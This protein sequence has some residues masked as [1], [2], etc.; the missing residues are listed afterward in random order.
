MDVRR[1][2]WILISVLAIPGVA[3]AREV[4]VEAKQVRRLRRQ[5]ASA[6]RLGSGDFVSGL[7]LVQLGRRPSSDPTHDLVDA[8]FIG[9]QQD[10]ARRFS[11]TV[12]TL[13]AVARLSHNDAADAQLVDL[14][15]GQTSYPLT[16]PPDRRAFLPWLAALLDADGGYGR[17]VAK[18][19]HAGGR[20]FHGTSFLPGP[21]RDLID[22][23]LRE[24]RRDYDVEPVAVTRLLDP[25]G[26]EA[27]FRVRVKSAGTYVFDSEGSVVHHGP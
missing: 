12:A 13:K 6:V 17:H 10:K 24:V 2:A 3:G 25:Q 23:K 4:G 21:A 5:V 1:G 26:S 8:E 22:L 20:E 27:G 15:Q 14:R 9:L 7:Q 16:P 11:P 18:Y 19:L